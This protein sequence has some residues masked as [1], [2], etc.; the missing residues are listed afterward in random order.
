[1]KTTSSVRPPPIAAAA[2][3]E[4]EEPV[5]LCDHE[6]WDHGEELACEVLGCPCGE[7]CPDER[8]M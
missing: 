7:Y 4:E 3:L 5:C 1:M 6:R 2:S 8:W